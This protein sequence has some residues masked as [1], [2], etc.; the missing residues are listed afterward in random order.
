MKIF[1][2]A[3][4]Q[5]SFILLWS[6]CKGALKGK[7]KSPRKQV[8]HCTWTVL[9]S[10]L[11]QAPINIFLQEMKEKAQDASRKN[12]F[13]CFGDPTWNTF[14]SNNAFT[15]GKEMNPA[16]KQSEK[17]VIFLTLLQSTQS[18]QK[19]RKKNEGL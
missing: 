5:W 9:C 10:L 11:T 4:W 15:I 6:R 14:V 2:A 7:H 8:L 18:K 17:W 16:T 12:N 19:W 3:A 1:Q 13:K